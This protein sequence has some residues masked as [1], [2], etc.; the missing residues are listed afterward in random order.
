MTK[1]VIDIA[2]E[3]IGKALAYLAKN[4]VR[5]TTSAFHSVLTQSLAKLLGDVYDAGY[6]AGALDAAKAH[7][8]AK[9]ERFGKA[10]LILT[11]GPRWLIGANGK[12]EPHDPIPYHR[13]PND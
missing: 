1:H 4:G 9:I 12:L 3:F 2:H 7:T 5:I 6:T 11:Y 10:R 8:Q 13:P